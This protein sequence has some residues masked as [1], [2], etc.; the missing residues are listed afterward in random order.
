MT[1][2][3]LLNDMTF[4][5]ES[6]P[7]TVV[8]DQNQNVDFIINHNSNGNEF[9]FYRFHVI[10]GGSALG[11]GTSGPGS[12]PGLGHCVVFLGKTLY[13]HSAS[14]HPGV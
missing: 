9:L 6:Q 10:S 13:S 3:L 4:P 2:V 1:V 14:L 5:F 11:S 8:K 12:N 7:L